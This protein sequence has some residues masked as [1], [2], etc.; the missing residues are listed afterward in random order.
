MQVQWRPQRA[1]IRSRRGSPV[2]AGAIFAGISLIFLGIGLFFLIDTLHFLSS[3]TATATGTIVSCPR[4]KSSSSACTPTVEFTTGKG[5][6]VSFT[7]SFSSS[8]FAVGQKQPVAYDPGNPQDARIG[9]FLTL[10]FLPVLFL[11][12]GGLFFLIG[13]VA[14][15][16]GMLRR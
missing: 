7:T 6:Q 5:Q 12:I 4:P 1:S 9:S 2:I 15:L 8:A 14:L 16:V 13:G 11:G 10:W 3:A